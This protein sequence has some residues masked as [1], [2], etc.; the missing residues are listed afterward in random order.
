MAMHYM[1]LE[2]FYEQVKRS[3][4]IHG[5]FACMGY[6]GRETIKDVPYVEELNAVWKKVYDTMISHYPKVVQ[7]KEQAWEGH[8][9]PFE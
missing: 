5:T 8:S 2:P 3:M 1:D 7:R 6:A 9:F 4:K